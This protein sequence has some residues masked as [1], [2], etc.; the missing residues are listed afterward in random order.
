MRANCPSFC[1]ETA[2]CK[3]QGGCACVKTAE[4]FATIKSLIPDEYI[5]SNIFSFDGCIVD[6]YGKKQR[7]IKASEVERVRRSMWAFLYKTEYDNSQSNL[8]RSEINEISALDERFKQ[9]SNVIIHGDQK[10]AQNSNDDTSFS[11]II[12]K[13][14]PMGKTLLASVILMDAIWRRVSPQNKARTYDR[15]SFLQLRQA[16]KRQEDIISDLE[17]ADWL[18]IDDICKIEQSNSATWTKETLDDFLMTRFLDKKPTILVFD[19]D[20]EKVSLHEIMGMS[21]AKIAES[22]NTFKIKV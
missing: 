6:A 17:N 5:K 4:I 22:Q 10:K 9:G 1:A 13:K 21:I 7:V 11:K 20:I 18:V 2:D 8:S 15:I 12:L 19:F 3:R 16:L 14:Q